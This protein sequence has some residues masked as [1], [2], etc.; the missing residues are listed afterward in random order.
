MLTFQ[1]RLNSSLRS[2]YLKYSST[3]TST[4]PWTSQSEACGSRWRRAS[5]VSRGTWLGWKHSLG[6]SSP[7]PTPIA[8]SSSLASPASVSRWMPSA[9]SG[10]AGGS[11]PAP[12][13]RK[14]PAAGV[15][16]GGG[17]G[18]LKSPS[19]AR[20]YHTSQ[21]HPSYT[22]GSWS[23]RDRDILA[24]GFGNRVATAPIPSCHFMDF[25]Q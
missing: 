24:S 13:P 18:S 9:C 20:S 15:G 14:R 1:K 4:S 17:R 6:Q 21:G 23:Q 11:G 22:P 2:S 7:T 5:R 3:Y 8:P 12:M 10:S 19:P 25:P 16:C